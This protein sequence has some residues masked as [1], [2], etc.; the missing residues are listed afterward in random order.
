MI[1]IIVRMVTTKSMKLKKPRKYE[2]R[3]IITPSDII[4]DGKEEC[5]HL[6]IAKVRKFVTKVRKSMD[7]SQEICEEIFR[8][9]SQEI[10]DQILT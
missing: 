1:G 6:I 2:S 8:D 4:W 10:H 3:W 5:Y 7:Q 9:Q